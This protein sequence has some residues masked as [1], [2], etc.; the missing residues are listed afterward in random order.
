MQLIPAAVLPGLLDVALHGRVN[1]Q[2]LFEQAGIDHELVG[3]DDCYIT[4]AQLDRLLTG[5]FSQVDSSRFGLDVGRASHPANLGLLGQ[6]MASA[7]NL[8][9]VLACLFQFKDLI[10]PYLQFQWQEKGPLA[11]LLVLPDD[12]LT[13]TR[14]RIHNDVVMASMVA[15]GRSLA[16]GDLGLVG[17]GLRHEEP[18]SLDDYLDFYGC[19]PHFSCAA[20]ELSLRRDVLERPLPGAYPKYHQRL[21]ATAADQLQRL[22]LA[23]GLSGKVREL[24]AER[25]ADSAAASIETIAAELHLTVRTLQR[26]LRQE[27]VS[28]MQLRDRLRHAAACRALL[29]EECDLGQLAARLGFSESANFSHAFRRWQGMSPGAFRRQ[30]RRDAGANDD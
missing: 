14:T 1:L 6:L 10:A 26:R 15:I 29:E 7:A 25:L 2:Q 20:N 9:E 18:E 24:L 5:A 19:R 17:I 22:Q 21:R 3:R 8:R 23:Q 16:G 4:L 11:R 28:F 13:F 12:S 27:G 30:H